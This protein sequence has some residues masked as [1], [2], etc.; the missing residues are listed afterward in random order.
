MTL[1]GCDRMRCTEESV[2]KG[3][4][5]ERDRDESEEVLLQQVELGL[6]WENQN[7]GTPQLKTT[8]TAA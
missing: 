5:R 7:I 3:E 2:N 6:S 4:V 8:K 1:L